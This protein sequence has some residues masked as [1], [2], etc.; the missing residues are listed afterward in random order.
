MMVQHNHMK[1]GWSHEN[2]FGR[3]PKDREESILQYPWTP[4]S[5]E[6]CLCSYLSF[7]LT[8]EG[9]LFGF[10]SQC[11]SGDSQS[12]LYGSRQRSFFSSHLE[13]I[14]HCYHISLI[15]SLTFSFQS[16]G[17]CIKCSETFQDIVHSCLCTCISL[18][19]CIT[20]QK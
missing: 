18:H 15:N 12:L 2:D 19:V 3:I 11:S 6:I 5:H 20:K 1:D 8:S 14:Q 9:A 16:E 17:Y 7:P 13:N 10:H 4:P